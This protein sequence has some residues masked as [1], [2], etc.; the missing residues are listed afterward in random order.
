[1]K[2]AYFFISTL[3]LFL[4]SWISLNSGVVKL[5]NVAGLLLG[6]GDPASV[7]IMQEIRGPRVFAAILVGFILGVGGALSQGALGN[8]LAEP[9]LLGTTGGAALFTLLGISIFDAS[10]GSP[11]AVT[12]GVLGA[13][14]ATYLT[15]L[16]GRKSKGG[17][18]FIVI[19]IAV[20][21][22]LISCVGIAVVMINQPEA[23]GITFWS[24]GTLSM[25]TLSHVVM[26]VPVIFLLIIAM[27][28]IGPNLDYLGIG[29]LRA[30]HLGKNVPLIRFSTFLCIAISVGTVTSIFGQI[31]FLALA[32][33]HIARS[34]VGV[35]HRQVL[36]LSGLVGAILIVMSDLLARTLSSP[37]ELPIGFMTAII[38]APVLIL[39]VR[40][41]TRTHA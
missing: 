27:I 10:I 15:Y 5:H 22:L 2:K 37:N 33:P 25:T 7:S 24:L 34:L 23:R 3:L 26:L 38:G 18:A 12:W 19:G 17:F 6:H 20:S 31:S 21:A 29:D 1:M 9:V 11:I 41:W 8:P 32:V 39:A 14:L 4:L 28:K 40:Q 16:L 36:F 13:C 30:R 35:K